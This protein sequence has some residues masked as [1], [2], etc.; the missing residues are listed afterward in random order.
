[1]SVCVIGYRFR[2]H[3]SIDYR[4]RIDRI[5]NFAIRRKSVRAYVPLGF[6][7]EKLRPDIFLDVL[8]VSISSGKYCIRI[9]K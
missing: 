7:S 8:I 1:M 3:E 4:R 6:Y 2:K 5:E 9:I